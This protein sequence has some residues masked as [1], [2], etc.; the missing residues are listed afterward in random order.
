MNHENGQNFTNAATVAARLQEVIHVS[1]AM[2]MTALNAKIITARAGEQGNAFRPLTDFVS[3]LAKNTAHIVQQINA[4]SLIVSKNSVSKT[5]ADHA[6]RAFLTAQ[7][8]HNN[9]KQEELNTLVHQTKTDLESL[10]KTH[11]Q[12]ATALTDLLNLI[13]QQIKSS[14][15]IVSNCRIEASHIPQYQKEFEALALD[16]ETASSQI[17]NII[18]NCDK[19]LNS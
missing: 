11:S 16:I 6:H 5:R 14:R 15:Y 2:N 19:L 10:A 3:E 8:K 4:S 17:Q 13:K 1:E 12:S 7:E 9:I 18:N